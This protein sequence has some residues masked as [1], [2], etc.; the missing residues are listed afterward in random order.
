MDNEN[1]NLDD[2]KFRDLLQKRIT[3]RVSAIVK[4]LMEFR[5]NFQ[6]SAQSLIDSVSQILN[7]VEEEF[8]Q[9][10]REE[11][12][13]VEAG[14]RSRLEPE[15]RAQMESEIRQQLESEFEQRTAAAKNSG[16]ETALQQAHARMGLLDS[17]LKEI[18]LQSNQVDILTCYLDKAAQFASRAAL[19]VMKAGSLVGWQA[20]GFEGDFN[21]ASIKTLAFPADR[22][23]FLRQVADTRTACNT[24]TAGNPEVMDVVSRFG[25]LA[26]DAVCAIPLVVRDKTVA[27]L[28]ADSGLIPNA[29][30]DGHSLEIVTAVVSLTVELSSARAKLGVKPQ[31][32]PARETS[33]SPSP[34]V[35][36]PPAAAPVAAAV[37]V[38]EPPQQPVEPPAGQ[39]STA[40]SA[41]PAEPSQ[42]TLA[43]PAV[44]EAQPSTYVPPLATSELSEADQKLHNDARKFARL[45]GVRGQAVQRTTSSG[46]KARQEALQLAA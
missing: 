1:R 5:S 14:V 10:L 25:P 42:P 31:D 36:P 44:A 15:L 23:N 28:Y 34:A 7:T 39:A 21:N 16:A 24:A 3:S 11:L 37:P 18:T 40:A 29:T 2:V 13:H 19:F 26:P 4:D 9:D 22:D 30:V 32:A 6:Q 17:A 46:G 43:A 38:V 20:R 45:S 27:V 8:L 41:P 35:S 12:G 33:A